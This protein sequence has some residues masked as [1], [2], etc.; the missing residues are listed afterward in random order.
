[1]LTYLGGV[2]F[3]VFYKNRAEFNLPLRPYLL[4]IICHL[5][6]LYANVCRLLDHPIITCLG[7]S[8][9]ETRHVKT[10]AQ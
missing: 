8:N 5:I 9:D 10:V 7:T 2:S 3:V 4:C 6:V 1:M